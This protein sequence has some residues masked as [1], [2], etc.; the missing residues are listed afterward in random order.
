MA[1]TGGYQAAVAESR[2]VRIPLLLNTDG[3]HNYHHWYLIL[4]AVSAA[5]GVETYLYPAEV[6]VTG[7]QRAKL[8]VF[9]S[10][11]YSSFDP[12]TLQVA[13]ADERCD[14]YD[15]HPG[16]VFAALKAHACDNTAR[17]H[18]QL[19]RRQQALTVEPAGT[20]KLAKSHIQIH[21]DM[22]AGNTPHITVT[23]TV[24]VFVRSMRDAPIYYATH[25]AVLTPAFQPTTLNDLI[26]LAEDVEEHLA[27]DQTQAMAASSRGGY[28]EGGSAS[29]RQGNGRGRARGCELPVRPRPASYDEPR[30]DFH[31][32]RYHDNKDCRT[33]HPHLAAF[34]VNEPE[35]DGPHCTGPTFL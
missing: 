4:R 15:M 13:R 31:C 16:A 3:S 6:S 26:H 34:G 20:I 33:Q 8:A 12:S 28:T 9:K 11:I 23:S 18:S 24:T 2:P 30:C 17:L 7:P 27:Q 1:G 19:L 5:Q 14:V 35:N 29:N 22:L 32:T 10:F 21:K 25:I